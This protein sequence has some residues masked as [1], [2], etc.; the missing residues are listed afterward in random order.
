LVRWRFS[1]FL[2]W[3]GDA[4]DEAVPLEDDDDFLRFLPA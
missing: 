3:F 4:L 1:L 2:R